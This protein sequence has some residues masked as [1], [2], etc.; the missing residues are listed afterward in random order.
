MDKNTIIRSEDNGPPK[1]KIKTS[2]A[3]SPINTP[4]KKWNVGQILD[5]K[6]AWLHNCRQSWI[7]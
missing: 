3:Q 7:D 4:K 1:K 6:V 5:V 2:D